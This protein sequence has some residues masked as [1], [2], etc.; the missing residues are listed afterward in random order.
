MAA[1]QFSHLWQALDQLAVLVQ[2]HWQEVAARELPTAGERDAYIQGLQGGGGVSIRLEG[3]SLTLTVR[4]DTPQA[5][6][7]EEGHAAYHLPDR[8]DWGAVSARRAKDGRLYLVIPFRHYSAQRGVRAQA[9]SPMAR[10]AALPRSVYTVAQRLQAGQSLTA[11]PTRPPLIHAPGLVP[12]Q[13]RYPRNVR[14]D[15]THASMYERLQ[16]TGSGRGTRYLTF[17]TLR[18]DSPGWWIPPKA[19]RHLAALTVREIEPQVHD[20]IAAAARQDMVQ[21]ISASI[22]SGSQR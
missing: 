22:T 13:P 21:L 3:N 18:Q 17:R 1:P 11:G 2:Q 19:G 5:R 9:S 7:I 20:L 10:R 14:P 15:Y 4:N 6:R 8:I 16:R 12:Y